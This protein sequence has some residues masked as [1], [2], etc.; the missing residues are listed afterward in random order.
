MSLWWFALPILLLPVWWHRQKRESV[1]AVPLATARFLP[2]ADPR[3]VRVWKWSDRFLLLLR[4]LLLVAV[5][6]RLADLMFPW[7]GDAVLVAPGTDAGWVDRQAA[8]VGMASAPRMQMDGRDVLAWFAAHEREWNDG[9]RVLVVG[10]VAMPAQMPRLR[11]T[12]ILRTRPS[13]T[14]P[15]P[16]RVLVTSERA[17]A[18]R[19]FFD[20]ASASGQPYVAATGAAELA[21]WDN[22]AAPPADRKAG[23]WWVTRPAAFPQL[24]QARPVPATGIA[25]FRYA[26]TPQGRVWTANSL[27]PADADA[28]GRLFETWQRL[29][30]APVP[31][32]VPSHTLQAF[33][34]AP[35]ASG[36]GAL[37]SFF[38]MLLIA[39]FAAERILTHVRRR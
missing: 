13:A 4:C 23:L 26:D 7:R 30:Y 24:A 8:A 31:Y 37:R 32:T 29:H 5:I 35:L 9:A 10:D 36:S 27:P 14:K 1:K 16:R 38:N 33:A 11:H 12:V 15:E 6:V 21:V 39:L 28:A 22:A 20:A 19:A 25:G 18:W 2:Q 34:G 3:Q 17:A